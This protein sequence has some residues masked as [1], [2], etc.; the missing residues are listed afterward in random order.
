MEGIQGILNISFSLF[1]AFLLF[2]I[3]NEA[4]SFIVIP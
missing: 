3:L 4:D 2:Q 1:S